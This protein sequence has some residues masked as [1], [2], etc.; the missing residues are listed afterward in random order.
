V[1]FTIIGQHESLN[2]IGLFA[3]TAMMVC[4]ALEGHSPMVHPGFCRCL[5]LGSTY[6]FLTCEGFPDGQCG[7]TLFAFWSPITIRKAEEPT[8]PRAR[9]PEPDKLQVPLVAE[10][11]VV[12]K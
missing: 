10:E 12:S 5:P 1:K 3:V 6:G 8:D 7:S 9:R 11:A 4:Y 2:L